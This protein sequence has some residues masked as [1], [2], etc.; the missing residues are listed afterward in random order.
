MTLLDL[1][2]LG[3]LDWWVGVC[4][5]GCACVCVCDGMAGIGMTLLDL[6][7]LG[8]LDGIVLAWLGLRCVCGRVCTCMWMGVRRIYWFGMAWIGMN[9]TGLARL[10]LAYARAHTRHNNS[11]Q[12]HRDAMRMWVLCVCVCRLR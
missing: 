9:W 3:L 11:M 5:G 6:D 7:W 2:W 8:V 4:V 1:D 12:A 10:G